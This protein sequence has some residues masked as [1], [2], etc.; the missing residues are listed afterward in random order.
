MCPLHVSCGTCTAFIVQ[1]G[2]AIVLP[3][4]FLREDANET[5]PRSPS[6][7]S[8]SLSLL[9]NSP[10]YFLQR[11]FGSEVSR[12]QVGPQDMDFLSWK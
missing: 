10:E 11:I 4:F 9:R 6:Q 7:T 3:V 2:T 5:F 12:L 1:N 8:H